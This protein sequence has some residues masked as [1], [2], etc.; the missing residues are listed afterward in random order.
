MTDREARQKQQA[1]DIGLP[2]V[3]PI[4]RLSS[5]QPFQYTYALD[6]GR[7]WEG[8]PS[9][10][11]QE[12]N[13]ITSRNQPLSCQQLCEQEHHGSDVSEEKMLAC[14]EKKRRNWECCDIALFSA[15]PN[16][17][18][19]VDEVNKGEVPAQIMEGILGSYDQ[20]FWAESRLYDQS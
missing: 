14:R 8:T 19:I 18:A 16:A 20:L 2:G 3:Q 6:I 9:T 7:T 11:L 12:C 4:T 17:R 5:I 15:G 10:L 13:S 1:A